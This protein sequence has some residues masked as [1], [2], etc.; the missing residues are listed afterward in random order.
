MGRS[1]EEKNIN[2]GEKILINLADYDEDEMSIE[3]AHEERVLELQLTMATSSI[4]HE[5]ARIEYDDINDYVRREELLGFMSECRNKYI[6]ARSQ[7]ANYN[8]LTLEE[9]ERDLILQKLNTITHYN[10]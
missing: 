10:A 8:P 5:Y 4:N 6:C 3:E 7:L 1:I 2:E 9:F